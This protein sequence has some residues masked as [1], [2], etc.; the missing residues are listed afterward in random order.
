MSP[1]RIGDLQL[2]VTELATN[3]LEHGGG[4]CRLAFW[5]EAGHLVCE[6]R[7]IGYLADPLVGRRPPAQGSGPY[8]LFVVNAIADLVH[9]HT[10]P[11]GTAIHAYLR[12]AHSPGEEH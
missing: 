10:S 4:V 1:E 9:T 5:H 6:A 11:S 7:D 8:G 12:L 2:I 3:S